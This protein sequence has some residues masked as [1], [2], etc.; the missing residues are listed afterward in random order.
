MK[1]LLY[2]LC[3]PMLLLPLCRPAWSAHQGV[4]V[5]A[6][7]GLTVLDEAE[8]KDDQGTFHLDFDPGQVAAFTLGY[9]L[10]PKGF[11]GDGRIEF[12][13]ARRGNS[14]DK[15]DFLEGEVGGKGDL[16]VECLLFS[17]KGVY[18]V[19]RYWVPYFGAGFGA[20]RVEADDL[21]ISGQPLADDDDVVFAYQVGIGADI[22]LTESLSF[23]LGYRF[24]GTTKPEFETSDG[25]DFKVE[26][27]S[28]NALVGLRVGF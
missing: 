11:L 1:H 20:A 7:Y 12:E 2:L 27:F 17:T 14:L 19:F 16:Q 18:R 8:A 10:N 9:D 28:H 4:Y 6:F 13:Y 22:P 3:L 25:D 15:V 21:R 26:Y 23:D 5:G 24:F